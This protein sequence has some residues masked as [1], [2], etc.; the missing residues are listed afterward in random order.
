MINGT[1]K[2]TFELLAVDWVRQARALLAAAGAPDAAFYI[3]GYSVEC[4]LKAVITKGETLP[5]RGFADRVYTHDLDNLLDLAGLRA[6][7]GHASSANPGLRGS[8][9]VVQTWNEAA[10]YTRGRS[11]ADVER[12]LDA[13]DHT[14]DGILPWLQQK[15]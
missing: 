11:Q 1:T 5:D 3:A 10:R 2:K 14:S 7:F 12:F 13:I 15:W 9:Q 8:W 6:T 4:A